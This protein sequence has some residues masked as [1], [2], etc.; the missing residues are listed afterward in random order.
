MSLPTPKPPGT[1]SPSSQPWGPNQADL[2]RTL[3]EAAGIDEAVFAKDHALSLGQLRTLEMRGTTPFY[4]EAI[5]SQIGHR[6]LARLG[7][8]EPATPMP[9]TAAEAAWHPVAGSGKS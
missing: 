1:L 5:K 9:P 2:L 6:L 4:S 7:Y 3:R 8:V